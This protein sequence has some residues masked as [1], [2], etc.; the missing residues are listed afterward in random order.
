MDREEAGPN[1][2]KLIDLGAGGV[3]AE[4][5]GAAVRAQWARVEEVRDQVLALYRSGDGVVR[6]A[7]AARHLRYDSYFLVMAIRQLLRTEE[8]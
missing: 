2:D 5:W 7:P 1:I 8:A 6:D 3:E 4:L